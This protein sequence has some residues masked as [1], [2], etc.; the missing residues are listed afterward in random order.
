MHR[1]AWR[2]TRSM[3]RTRS[4]ASLSPTK[5]V[6]PA[7]PPSR[8]ERNHRDA[9]GIAYAGAA[10]FAPD[11]PTPRAGRARILASSAKFKIAG[12]QRF[13]R[14]FGHCNVTGA[15]A[16]S[17]TARVAAFTPTRLRARRARPARW[18]CEPRD[19]ASQPRISASAPK[20][21]PRG[22]R[23][24][25][26]GEPRAGHQ[27]RRDAVPPEHAGELYARERVA[28]RPEIFQWQHGRWTRIVVDK[29]Y[30]NVATPSGVVGLWWDAQ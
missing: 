17:A 6:R 28:L 1:S 25:R 9:S 2:R 10:F 22:G 12:V 19:R 24:A 23:E 30:G 4:L 18:H 16:K 8:D 26:I 14:Y 27:Q 21:V 15:A 13:P 5:V 3:P 29:W 11:S 20:H 7:H